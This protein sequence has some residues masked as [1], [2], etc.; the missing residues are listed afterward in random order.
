MPAPLRGH[1]PIV[2]W[3]TGCMGTGGALATALPTD[4]HPEL[5]DPSLPAEPGPVL[6]WESVGG[7]L[8]QGQYQ[9]CD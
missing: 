5:W 3:G 9:G 4:P 2:R 6:R 7:E 8:P 1:S